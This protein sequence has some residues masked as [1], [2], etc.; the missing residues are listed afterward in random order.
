MDKTHLVGELIVELLGRAKTFSGASGVARQASIVAPSKM[1]SR[2][3]STKSEQDWLSHAFAVSSIETRKGIQ[4]IQNT[5]L[6]PS[7][8]TKNGSVVVAIIEEEE[9]S[10]RYFILPSGSG[11]VLQKGTPE[12]VTVVTPKS[13]VGLALLGSTIGDHREVKTPGGL[14]H[15]II[16]SVE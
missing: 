13:P 12:Q 4:D 1:E 10:E 3:D 5:D 16:L 15:L 11:V 6:T 14:Y 9:Q 7:E 8:K 2:Y